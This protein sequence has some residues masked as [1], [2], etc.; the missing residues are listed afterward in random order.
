MS[1]WGKITD[2]NF[3]VP[4]P[5]LFLALDNMPVEKY[6]PI[7]EG[8]LL[9]RTAMFAEGVT[10][11]AAAANGPLVPSQKRRGKRGPNY[12][13][14]SHGCRSLTSSRQELTTKPFNTR[15]LFPSKGLL[16]RPLSK[17]SSS[18]SR[19]EACREFLHRAD[20]PR[21]RVHVLSRPDCSPLGHLR[22]DR[23][24]AG[25]LA[26]VTSALDR[27]SPQPDDH[28]KQASKFLL[29]MFSGEKPW[30]QWHS[31]IAPLYANKQWR[32]GS[33]PP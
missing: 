7:Q 13:T 23:D 22:F 6:Q 4:K 32:W 12:W 10:N 1:L 30:T 33:L 24:I 27:L 19:P 21:S 14:P 9:L 8:L 5:G 16:T 20:G 11:S 26:V 25:E 28:W 2:P 31:E 29:S 17:H 15:T 18:L 3:A